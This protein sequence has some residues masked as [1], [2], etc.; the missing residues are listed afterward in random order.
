MARW[1]SEKKADQKAR[2]AA[3][4]SQVLRERRPVSELLAFLRTLLKDAKDEA[5]P[6]AAMIL[7]NTLLQQPHQAEYENEAF[8]LL[9]ALAYGNDAGQKLSIQVEALYRLS[10]RMVTARTEA[11]NKKIERP[12]QLTRTEFRDKQ[13]ANQK[14]AREGFVDRLVKEMTTAPAELSLWLKIE[15][16]YLDI[17]LERNA[18]QV[19]ADCWEILGAEPPPTIDAEKEFTVKDQLERVLKDRALTMIIWLAAQPKADPRLIEKLVQFIDKGIAREGEASG[20]KTLKQRVLIALDR[21]KDLENNLREWIKAGDGANIWKLALGFLI[22]EQG[23]LAEAVQLFESIEA[24]DEL[25]PLGYRAMAG[26]YQVLNQREKHE[27]ATIASYKTVDEYQLSRMLYSKLQPWQRGDRHLPSELDKEVLWILTALFEKSAQPQNYLSQVQQFYAACRDF[28]LLGTLA[29]SVVGQ[30]AGKIYPFLQN[31]GHVF[32]EVR[33]EA[34]VDEMM[35]H[36]KKVREKAK[37]PIDHRA[38][39]LMEVLVRRR[40][41]ELQNQPGPHG[42]KALEAM[43]RAFDRQWVQDEQPLMAH[44]LASLG[45]IAYKPLADEQVREL[46]ELLRMQKAGTYHRLDVSHHLGII[47]Y[48]YDRKEKALDVLFEAI[49]DYSVAHKGILP[50]D[51]NG[52]IGTLVSYLQNIGQYQR[53]ENFLLDELKH[54]VHDQQKLW[55]TQQ[56]FN[57]YH[58]ALSNNGDVSIGKGAKLYKALEQKLRVAADTPDAQHHYQVLDLLIRVYRTAHSLKFTEFADDLRNFGFKLLPELLKKHPTYYDSIVQTTSQAMRDLIGP[59]EGIAFLLDRMENE[60]TWL[61]LNNQDG[62]SRY[63]YS[64]AH[65]R[66]EVKDLGDLEPRLLKVVLDELRKDLESRQPRN[67]NMYAR[68]HNHY[69]QEKE[70]DFAKVAEE[71]HTARKDSGA[72]VKHIADYFYHGLGRTNRAIEILFAAHERKLLDEAGRVQL[73]TY[74]QSSDR[75]LEAIALLLPL[76]EERPESLDYRTRLMTSYHATKQRD[77]LSAT[78]KAADAYFHQKDRWNQAVIAG[79]AY[80]CLNTELYNEAVAYFTEVIPL[81]QRSAARRGV[82]DGTLADYYASLGRAY[83]RLGK[84]AEAI[85]AVSGAIVAWPGDHH[86]RSRHLQRLQEV[87]VE[88][89]NLDA[90]VTQLDAK[91][92]AAA[93]GSP[94]LRKA[95]GKAYKAK[96]QFA[97]ALAQ[98]KIASELQ[99][100]DADTH[101]EM[102]A[103]YDRLNDKEGAVRQL[104][105]AVQVSRRNILLYEQMGVRYEQLQ[106]PAD[107]ERAFTS[108]V[109]MQAN[110]TESHT[111]LAQVR[112]RQNR[113]EEAA[114]HWQRVAELR[115]LEPTGLLELAKAQIQM[116]QWDKAS[117]TVSRLEKKSWP[118]RFTNV[119]EEAAGLRVKVEQGKKGPN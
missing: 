19:A 108:M 112:Q 14:H 103:C 77:K 69:W 37:T 86:E 94:V 75:H 26:W 118:A 21:P 115:V 7:F 76:I 78:L 54:P 57:L 111:K 6:Q 62:W 93:Q 40:A 72:S 42:D 97:K 20:W 13:N 70:A 101:Q 3:A 10:D 80:A 104:Y 90:Y 27:R 55:L 17:R 23:K 109:E 84:T 98:F 106:R 100:E 36:L 68:G 87:M 114:A 96:E 53:G 8:A 45:R 33:E 58:S 65:W 46:E 110:E 43:K 88:S 50:V 44:L 64:L 59:K 91:E 11:L 9:P 12:D 85:D 1:Q 105:E 73:I 16:M 119:R 107:A 81:H 95:L 38:L 56:L 22:A 15:R 113:W 74:L 82:G 24:A 63:S 30:T 25:G 52:V 49:K 89:A 71:V 83:S 116:K 29:D 99:P 31:M 61:R 60:P 66:T 32:Q 41:A 35:N 92:A 47:Y 39:D 28:R 79:L 18:A 34:T 117:E 51:A 4:L 48:S 2:I 102:I 67:R 5:K